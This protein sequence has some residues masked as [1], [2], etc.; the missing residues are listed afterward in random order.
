M[1]VAN[2]SVFIRSN[3]T[4]WDEQLIVVGIT[5]AAF[6]VGCFIVMMLGGG[7]FDLCHASCNMHGRMLGMWK[8]RAKYLFAVSGI[9][10]YISLIFGI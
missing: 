1:L 6:A 3:G 7:G 4:I 9:A 2:I 8:L 10:L 5:V